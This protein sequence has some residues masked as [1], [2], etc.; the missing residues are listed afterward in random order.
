MKR[1]QFLSTAA[2]GTALLSMPKFVLALDKDNAYRNEIGIQLYTLRNE[3]DKDVKA[4]LKAV[5]EAGYKQAEPYGFPNCRPM[6]EAA[7]EFG[8]KLHSSH[9]NSD[10]IVNNDASDD[11]YFDTVLEKANDVGLTHLVIPYLGDQFRTSLDDYRR[12]CANCN[13]AAEK[14]KAAGIQL[15]YH[16]H[17]FEFKPLEDG[18]CGYDVM[19]EEFSP[20]MKFELDVFWVEVGGVNTIELMSKL[21]S[22]ISQLHLK[23]LDASVK[24][25]SY[26][27]VPKEAFKEIGNGVINIE[28]IIEAA[29]EHGIAHCHVE[30]DQSPNALASIKQS[31]E[32]LKKM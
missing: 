29:G 15:S 13:K 14:A 24:T 26:D 3:I 18:K 10:S 5:A 30:Q 11:D 31:M 25:P 32:A 8:L 4:T 12:V 22:R 1:R 27:G 7:N 17:A 28:A 20:D 2:A 6:I 9:F 16:N 21:G 19:I 23:D